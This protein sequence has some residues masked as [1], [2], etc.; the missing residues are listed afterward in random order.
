VEFR[1]GQPQLDLNGAW[2]FAWSNQ[3]VALDKPTSAG[4]REAGL[5]VYPCTVPGNFELELQAIGII[6]DPFY[7]MNVLKLQELEGAHVW[8]VRNFEASVPDGCN[9]ELVFEGLDCYA[10]VYLNGELVGSCDNMLVEHTFNVDG[11]LQSHN[12]LLVHIKPAVLEA[13][14]YPYPPG[15]SA[16]GVNYESLYVRK[17]PHMYGWDIMP[18]V[19]S[20]GIWRPVRIRFL[21]L[22]R[23]Q[24]VYLQT[25]SLSAD[26]SRADLDFYYRART[27][28]SAGDTYEV[29]VEGHCNGSSFSEKRR[30][31][32]NAGR[33]GFSVKD[34]K[35][36]WPRGRGEPNLYHVTASLIKNGRVVDQLEFDMG[37][38]T[39][40]L[41]RTSVTTPSGDGEFCFRINGEKV[42]IMGSNW[43]PLDAFHARDV[44]RIAPAIELAED[45]GCNMLRCWG[46]NVYE[47]DLFYELCDRKGIMI[48]QDFA[49]AC[50]IYP[51]DEEFRRRIATEARKVVQRLRQHPC[52]VLWSGDNECD[53]AY[54]WSSGGKRNPNTNVL[55]REV[56]P[57]LLGEEDP[58]RPYLPSSPYIDEEA[59]AAGD[60]F[61]PENHLW[62]PRN[63]YKSDYYINALCH[64]ASEIGYHGC[65]SPDSIRRFIS[66]EKLWPYK[67]NPQWLLHATSPVPEAHL[68]DYRVELMATQIRELFGQV[69]DNIEQ[70]ALASQICQA[71]ADKFFIEF[72]RAAKWRRTGIIWWNLID[73]WPQ[74]S[75]AVVDYYFTRKLAYHYIKVSQQPLC[76]MLTEPEG[77]GQKLIA[78]N[79]TR[80]AIEL[81]YSI[82][83]VETDIVVIEGTGPAAPDDV[84]T[85]TTV[86]FSRGEQRFYV[87]EWES[88]HGSG[89]NHYLAGEPPFNLSQ[90]LR[91][92]EKA[93]LYPL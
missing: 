88:T 63:Y 43:V 42:F 61:L 55:T 90:Y 15:L 74:F 52:I 69:P 51:Q 35:P 79:D 1:N 73:G 46:G 37:I 89:K 19:V 76:L 12:E 49:M 44:E 82:R 56:L 20:A 54:L 66:P 41:D 2:S 38:R 83:D 84:T 22:E 67:D 26:A 64:F 58:A 16:L 17:A 53:N 31:R 30:L 68:Y 40:R 91:W 48:W 18:R 47:N 4:L 39:V 3:P 25:L 14:A 33:F 72:F 86:P 70:F 60:R 21:P 24:R 29:A 34:A 27:L 11:L 85:L 78:A 13:E 80:E 50:G 93:N 5:E 45:I 7:G 65:P 23:L 6:E 81:R 28:H 10:D 77:S 92:L 71:E 32:F 87:I 75:D 36:W 59:F 62:G 9:A 8:Y 57:R